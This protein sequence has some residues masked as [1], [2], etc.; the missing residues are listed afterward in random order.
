MSTA[1][2]VMVNRE[3]IIILITIDSAVSEPGTQL[4]LIIVKSRMNATIA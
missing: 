4:R 1:D 2:M 3:R